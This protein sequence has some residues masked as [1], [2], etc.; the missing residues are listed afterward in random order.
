MGEIF[1]AAGFMGVV[2]LSLLVVAQPLLALAK[3]AQAWVRIVKRLNTSSHQRVSEL[4]SPAA[5]WSE[6]G[7]RYYA[8]RELPT[9][10]GRGPEWASARGRSGSADGASVYRSNV[11][12]SIVV[13]CPLAGPLALARDPNK[14]V[15]LG[16][17][18]AS[19]RPCISI[20]AGGGAQLSV[21][22]W[23]GGCFGCCRRGC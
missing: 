15:M 7:N 2:L 23:S 21:I 14:I 22:D 9:T 1:S 11:G 19:S 13:G 8:R 18:A 5:T 6:L 10:P 3:Q 20:Y 4:L 16:V 17:G 12:G